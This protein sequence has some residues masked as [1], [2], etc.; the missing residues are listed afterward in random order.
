[1]T[2]SKVESSEETPGK[3]GAG[4]LGDWRIG[5]GKPPVQH[6]FPKGRPPAGS[7][8]RAGH[9]Q[10]QAARHG[11]NTDS[12]LPVSKSAAL[13]KRSRH[14]VFSRANSS[15]GPDRVEK[16]HFHPDPWPVRLSA[17][18][19]NPG[20]RDMAGTW[21]VGERFGLLDRGDAHSEPGMMSISDADLAYGA[22]ALLVQ[23]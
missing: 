22:K 21:G 3:V 7:D 13:D 12:L 14:I 16:M 17:A 1:M 11:S 6:Q 19:A 5:K 10:S 18:R 8:H 20:E 9:R 2:A 23:L 4:A 15:L